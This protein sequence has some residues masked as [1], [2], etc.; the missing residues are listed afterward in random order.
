MTIRVTRRAAVVTLVVYAFILGGNLAA[1]WLIV[2]GVGRDLA[3]HDPFAAVDLLVA[4]VALALVLIVLYSLAVFLVLGINANEERVWV[5]RPLGVREVNRS[6]LAAI[7]AGR[8]TQPLSRGTGIYQFIRRDGVEA[9]HVQKAIYAP[10]DVFAPATYL[11][12][13]LQS[14]ATSSQAQP[15]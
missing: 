5:R 7:R 10:G 13:P 12:V 4:F 8:S 9:F 11:R 6:D 2:P 15:D 14:A 1:L 3:R